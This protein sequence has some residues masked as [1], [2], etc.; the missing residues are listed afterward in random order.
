[1]IVILKCIWLLFLLVY[2]CVIL[3]EFVFLVI[4]ISFFVMSGCDNVE[5]RGYVFLYIKFFLIV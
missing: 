1:M 3:I 2:L 5:I 4:L